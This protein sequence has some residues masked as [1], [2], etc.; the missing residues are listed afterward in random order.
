MNGND[1]WFNFEIEKNKELLI[2]YK[3]P[4]MQTFFRISY[5]LAFCLLFSTTTFAQMHNGQFGNEWIKHNQSYYKIKVAEDGFY[6]V[7]KQDNNMV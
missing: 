3:K 4:L 5:L 1:E 6:S 2:K 7:D